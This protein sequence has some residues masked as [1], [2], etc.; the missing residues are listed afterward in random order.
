ME[1]SINSFDG[2]N[3]YYVHKKASN[4]HTII[5]LHGIGANWTVWHK[6]MDFFAKK[7]YSY[8]APD[9]RG[10]GLSDWPHEAEKYH[11]FNFTKDINEII[12]KERIKDFTIVGHSLGGAI[13]INYCELFKAPKS[14]VLLDTAHRYPYTHH[15]EFNLSPFLNNILRFA[16]KHEHIQ[17]SIFPHVFKNKKKISTFRDHHGFL[18][19]MFYNTP[20]TCIFKCLDTIH[21]HTEKNIRN[22]EEVLKNLEIPVLIIAAEKDRVISPEFSKELH[23]LIKKSKLAVIKDAHHVVHVEKPYEVNKNIMKF[24]K[25]YQI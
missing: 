7:G 14:M 12:K 5:F 4:S 18:F 23:K 20:L 19:Q 3:I 1:K 6:E 2:T 9:L 17:H 8:I 21:E 15:H 22:T 10:H 11:F 16:A 13:A 25:K 24:F